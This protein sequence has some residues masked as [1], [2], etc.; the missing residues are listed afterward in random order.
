MLWKRQ[1][2]R[3]YSKL[4][5]SFASDLDDP[6]VPAAAC[7][8][9][10]SPRTA[11]LQK[12]YGPG[13]LSP[14]APQEM[15]RRGVCFAAM[16]QL[17]HLLTCD[18]LLCMLF[19]TQP[20]RTLVR[21]PGTDFDTVASFREGSGSSRACEPHVALCPGCLS[22]FCIMSENVCFRS[23]FHNFDVLGNPVEFLSSSQHSPLLGQRR[24]LVC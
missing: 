11:T 8:R 12:R 3:A 2:I 15:Y 7:V 24:R 6:P 17:N 14:V 9:T 23:I 5:T 22:Y 20:C 19:E 21:T 18:F 16:L 4:A 10:S 13:T 1:P